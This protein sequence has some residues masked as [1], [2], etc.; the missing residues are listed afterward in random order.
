M[1]RIGW[2]LIAL[3]VLMD[4]V[5]AVWILQGL[6]LLPGSFMTGDPFWTGAGVVMLVGSGLSL[7]FGVVRSA[8][9]DG[10]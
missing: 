4:L 10:E 3:T 5:G 2:P 7:A 8:R 1:Y 6:N 9:G